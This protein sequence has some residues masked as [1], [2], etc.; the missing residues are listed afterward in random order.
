MRVIILYTTFTQQSRNGSHYPTYIPQSSTKPTTP[1]SI[2]H[3]LINP[4]ILTNSRQQFPISET[5]NGGT[6]I[7]LSLFVGGL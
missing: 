1:N 2:Q 5:T 6:G 3:L 7:G 4:P